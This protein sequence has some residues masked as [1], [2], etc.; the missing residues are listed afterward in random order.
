LTV[1]KSESQEV[2]FV[3]VR[4]ATFATPLPALVA[5]NA[6]RII[7]GAI[8]IVLFAVGRLPAPFATSA[9]WGDI[10]A[11]AAALPLAWAIAQFG[12]RTRELAV[13]WNAIGISDLVA[14]IALGALS[15]PGPLQMF[16]GPPTSAIMTALPWLIVPGF[17]VRSL[18]FIHVVIFYRL[19]GTETSASGHPWLRVGRTRLT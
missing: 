16:A 10:F 8:F 14:A 9:G 12:S 4:N 11:G 15:A 19:A 3:L 6:I 7:P 1:C 18:V 17:I 2:D 13:L 5:I